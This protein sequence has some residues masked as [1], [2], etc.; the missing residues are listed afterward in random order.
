MHENWLRS[1]PIE[2]FHGWLREHLD[3]FSDE[4]DEEIKVD[5]KRTLNDAMKRAEASPLPE[6][7]D[8]LDGVWAEP[9]E[10]DTPHHK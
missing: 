4:R 1:D 2:R 7:D 3:D 6:P 9:E 8:A 5:V 10:L